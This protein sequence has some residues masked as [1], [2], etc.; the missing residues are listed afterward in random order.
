MIQGTYKILSGTGRGTTEGGTGARAY[1]RTV[2][3][4]VPCPSTMLCMV[5][6]PLQG[7][8]A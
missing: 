4:L 5:P 3:D 6:L 2:S 7:R 1:S 8:N